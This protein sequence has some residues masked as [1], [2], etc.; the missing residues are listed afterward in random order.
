MSAL[1]NRSFNIRVHIGED[2]VPVLG[3]VHGMY[4]ES[5][6]ITDIKPIPVEEQVALAELLGITGSTNPHVAR[7]LR[8]SGAE[9][10]VEHLELAM[11]QA[12]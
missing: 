6:E 8:T 11:G 7:L 4:R 12:A 5:D 9:L 1:A 10:A 2:G 3:W